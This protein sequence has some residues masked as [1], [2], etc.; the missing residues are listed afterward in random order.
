MYKLKEQ[1]LADVIALS[2]GIHKQNE[3]HAQLMGWRRV[4]GGIFA[5]T[6]QQARVAR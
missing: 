3:A 1:S 6:V 2:L 5:D 4:Q